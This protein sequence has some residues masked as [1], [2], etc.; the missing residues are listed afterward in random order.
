MKHLLFLL[1]II[2]SLSSFAQEKQFFG[3]VIDAE[4]KVGIP[5]CVVKAKDRNEGVYTDENGRFS[6]T[7]NTDSVKSFIFY[8][9]GYARREIPVEQLSTDSIT[10]ELQKEYTNLKETVI[11]ANRGRLRQK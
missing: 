1:T 4:K 6:F 7:S 9:L 3:K 2:I 11:V 5:F 10:V 8:S